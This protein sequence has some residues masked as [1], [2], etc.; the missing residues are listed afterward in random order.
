MG[1]FF[2]CE[3]YSVHNE[4]VDGVRELV[5]KF[6][7][8]FKDFEMCANIPGTTGSIALFVGDDDVIVV[9]TYMGDDGGEHAFVEQ[10]IHT[11]GRRY[12]YVCAVSA[13]DANGAVVEVLR[14]ANS[15]LGN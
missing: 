4:I 14:A 9:N 11:C 6:P 8:I 7:E 5:G 10:W 3:D 15:L 13:D 12:E 1:R 2:E